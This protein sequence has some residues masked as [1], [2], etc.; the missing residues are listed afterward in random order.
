MVAA[1]YMESNNMQVVRNQE[2]LK[3]ITNHGTCRPCGKCHDFFRFDCH[4]VGVIPLTSTPSRLWVL[5]GFLSSESHD[6]MACAT[7]MCAALQTKKKLWCVRKESLEFSPDSSKRN[8][9]VRVWFSVVN[10]NGIVI[11]SRVV[12]V[13]EW[14]KS[15]FV[16]F[17]HRY[18]K[19]IQHTTSLA[20]SR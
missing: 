20:R 18:H 15:K 13:R 8:Y 5:A 7:L 16:W 17:I 19:Q 1:A 2:Q 4:T 14:R 11:R 3:E 10:R 6:V 9:S 12:V